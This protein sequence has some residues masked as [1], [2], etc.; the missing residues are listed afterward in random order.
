MSRLCLL[1]VALAA[2]GGAPD[3]WAPELKPDGTVQQSLARCGVAGAYEGRATIT[4]V[5]R[6]SGPRCTVH[7][8]GD[9]MLA[10]A[11]FDAN[12]VFTGWVY[13]E[14]GGPTC[15]TRYEECSVHVDCAESAYEGG[16]SRLSWVLT[17]DPS[18]RAATG[19][20]QFYGSGEFCEDLRMDWSVSR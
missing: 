12:G 2:C 3:G 6:G 10:G 9:S 13:G 7:P 19:A 4:H 20:L 5:T 14:I 17:F 1:S 16:A 8:V 11:A 18:G 15:V